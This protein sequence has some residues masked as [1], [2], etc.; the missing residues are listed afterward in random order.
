MHNRKYTVYF[1]FHQIT[2][3]MS[4][5]ILVGYAAV[6]LSGLGYSNSALGL[7]LAIGSTCGFLLGTALSSLIDRGGK[8]SA[9]AVAWPVL[10]LQGILFLVLYLS[11]YCSTLTAVCFPA[12]HALLLSV[13]TVN[14]KIG[15]D[16]VHYKAS[17][18]YGVTRCLGAAAYLVLTALMGTLIAKLG[19]RIIPVLGV[20]VTLLQ[21][22]A[23][24]V[25]AAAL[26]KLSSRAQETKSETSAPSGKP[27]GVFLRQNPKYTLVLIGT[28]LIFYAHNAC[29]TFLIN[30]VEYAGGDTV[31]LGYLTAFMAAVEMPMMLLYSVFSRKKSCAWLLGA[32]FIFF[33]LKSV[34]FSIAKTIP[35]LYV[36]MA[37]QGPSFG[38]YS[39]AIVAYASLVIP[40][41]DS[42]KG[43]SLAFSMTTVGGIFASFISGRLFDTLTVPATLWISV[44][45]CVVGILLAFL[46]LEK[47]KNL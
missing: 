36:A 37:M 33:A 22:A 13:N 43:Q 39:A 4:F 32:S 28:A 45:V 16:L 40:Y 21:L 14:L 38:L 3:W 35:M 47:N 29:S 15:S 44:A 24:A 5:C 42:A 10:I 11:P 25:T 1:S 41:E 26:A 20:F 2:F 18:N 17:V 27:L 34:L 30:I 7:L 46:G 31:T 12:A 9:S 6:Y 23:N 8:Y 19:I